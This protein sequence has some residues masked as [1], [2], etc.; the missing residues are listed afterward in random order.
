MRLLRGLS[1]QRNMQALVDAWHAF[2]TNRELTMEMIRRELGSS[3][4]GHT[5]GPVWMFLHPLIIV[6]TYLLIFGFV[7][8]VRIAPLERFP[9]DFP[10]YIM[11]GLAPWL[12]IQAVLIKSTS[13]LVA[14]SSLVKQVVFPIE[15]L[16]IA[17]AL[18]A[19]L[20]FVPAILLAV[21]YK[22]L[23]GGGLPWTAVLLPVVI[24][25]H[26]ALAIGCSFALSALTCFMRDLREVV[27]VFCVVAMYITPA[28]YLPEWVPAVF[29]PLLYLNPFSYLTWVYQD[30]LF[31]GI[32]HPW[33]W[34]VLTLLAV[35]SVAGGY[36]LFKRLGPY[37]GNVL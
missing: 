19:L 15:I 23:F 13:A 4:A 2:A 27:N 33:A 29:R 28:V 16:P 7:I 34:V 11:I 17:S 1:P 35:I 5:L 8:G 9:G 10:S 30:T 25:L 21:L 12:A 22:L 14:N 20:T 37:Y 31:Y 6:G 36:R 26:V 32:D 18:S 24:V 3:H